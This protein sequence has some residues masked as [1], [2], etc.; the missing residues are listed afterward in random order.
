[1]MDINTARD[2]Y[3]TLNVDPFHLLLAETTI[4]EAIINKKSSAYLR[5][6]E[7]ISYIL[8]DKGYHIKLL[9][10]DGCRVELMVSGWGE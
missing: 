8:F 7:G 9:S 2:M 6:T 1:M 4:K 10:S 5:T 3:S